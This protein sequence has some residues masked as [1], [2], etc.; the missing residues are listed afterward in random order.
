MRR[1]Q[2]TEVTGPGGLEGNPNPDRDPIWSVGW[3]HKSLILMLL[4]GGTWHAYRLP[5]ASHAYDGA[6]GWNTEWP[7]IRDIGERDLLMTM[8]GMLWRFPRTFARANSAG[9]APRSTYLRVVGDFARWE[10]RIVFGSDDTAKSEFT[11][12]RIAKGKIAAPGQ[13]QS[14]LWLGVSDDLWQLGKARGEGGPWRNTAVRAGEPSDPYLMTGF[15]EK[16]LRLSHDRPAALGVRV[17]IDLTGSGL[18]VPYAT[19][20]LPAGRTFEH[21]FPDGFNACWVRAVALDDARVTAL[22]DYR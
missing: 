12:T 20:N 22:L 1:N 8:H 17:D 2:F 16:T 15:S 18:W 14:N 9:I 3:D 7:R 6:H 4:D 13:S 5:K 19:F 10:N 11:N 21:R